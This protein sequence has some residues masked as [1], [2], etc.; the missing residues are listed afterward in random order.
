MFQSDALMPWKTAE[1]N[2][3]MG[4]LF[5]GV[6]KKQAL[7]SARDW[8]RRVGLSGFERH[9]PH[10]LSGGMRNASHSHRH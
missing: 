2:V 1:G 7:E 6:P 9:H 5:S 4:P 8:L 10:E 3:A